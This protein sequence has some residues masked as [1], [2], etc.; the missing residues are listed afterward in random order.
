MGMITLQLDCRP[1]LSWELGVFTA[2]FGTSLGIGVLTEGPSPMFIYK[3]P[4]LPSLKAMLSLASFEYQGLPLEA[5]LSGMISKLMLPSSLLSL[6]PYSKSKT[7]QP[8]F[9]HRG[10]RSATGGGGCAGVGLGAKKVQGN[11]QG[12]LFILL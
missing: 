3:N 4:V 5:N 2:L 1:H 10:R 9:P 8:C 11:S 6:L 7:K 12:Q